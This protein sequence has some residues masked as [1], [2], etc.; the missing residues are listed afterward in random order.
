MI[1]LSAWRSDESSSLRLSNSEAVTIQ[2]RLLEA[3]AAG[4]VSRPPGSE[5]RA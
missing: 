5:E 4:G 3:N 2:P 1:S